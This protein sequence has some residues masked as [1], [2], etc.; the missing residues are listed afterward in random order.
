MSARDAQKESEARQE[1]NDEEL[2][3]QGANEVTV[4]LAKSSEASDA[5]LEKVNRF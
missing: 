1:Y 4:I 2:C 3:S 5:G